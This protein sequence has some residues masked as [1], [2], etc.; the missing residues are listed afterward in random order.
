MDSQSVRDY[1]APDALAPFSDLDHVHCGSWDDLHPR[2][3]DKPGDRCRNRRFR[4]PWRDL[5]IVPNDG[6]TLFLST[7][8]EPHSRSEPEKQVSRHLP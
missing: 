1:V 6:L 4:R 7:P 5:A 2:P 3:G 8:H